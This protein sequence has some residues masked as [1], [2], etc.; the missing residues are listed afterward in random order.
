MQARGLLT[1]RSRTSDNANGTSE[2][3]DHR[4]SAVGVGRLIDTVLTQLT[5]PIRTRLARSFETMAC[6]ACSSANAEC[7]NPVFPLGAKDKHQAS[8]YR[9]VCIPGIA[10]WLSMVFVRPDLECF[11]TRLS[12]VLHDSFP[13]WFRH[14]CHLGIALSILDVCSSGSIRCIPQCASAVGYR[15]SV[16]QRRYSRQPDSESRHRGPFDMPRSAWTGHRVSCR[17]TNLPREAHIL[18]PS[19][20]R[21]RISHS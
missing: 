8:G 10:K 15:S 19:P 21:V 13:A 5:V 11:R 2:R 14:D 7:G 20:C 1:M 12:V 9:V 4:R 16:L 18:P 6:E 3:P 17:A